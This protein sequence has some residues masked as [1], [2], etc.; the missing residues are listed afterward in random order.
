MCTTSKCASVK[1]MMWCL[2]V[3]IYFGAL[4]V[5]ARSRPN[6]HVL[7]DSWPDETTSDEMLSSPY[8]RMRKEME[9]FENY[10]TKS[11]GYKRS[12]DPSRV[13]Q[14]RSGAHTLRQYRVICKEDA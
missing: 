7:I 5:W 9:S 4:A 3:P 14:K 12:G 1:Y 6:F 11:Y 2:S 13:S 10:F 8:S